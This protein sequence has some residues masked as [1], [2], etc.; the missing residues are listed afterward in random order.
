MTGSQWKFGFCLW[1]VHTSFL[2]PKQSGKGR[3]KTTGLPHLFLRT[4]PACTPA[5]AERTFQ[6]HLPHIAVLH[7]SMSGH[8]WGKNRVCDTLVAQTLSNDW[9]VRRQ[10]LLMT[11]Q[12]AHQGQFKFLTVTRLSHLATWPLLKIH[13]GCSY[14]GTVPVWGWTCR[15]WEEEEYNTERKMRWIG[16]KPH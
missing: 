11:A 5:W 15:G 3:L 2:L 16:L 12:E 10:P 4:A 9:E 7:W 8:N 6:H 14:S 13:I 1:R